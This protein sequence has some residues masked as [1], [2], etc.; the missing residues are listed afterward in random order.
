VS[1]E[2]LVVELEQCSGATALYACG[3]GGA[4]KDFLPSASSYSYY[5]NSEQSCVS[6]GRAAKVKDSCHSTNRPVL[7]LPQSIGN[8]FVMVAGAGE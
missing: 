8:Y 6:S 4:C 1:R 5:S 7:S 3:D 2:S